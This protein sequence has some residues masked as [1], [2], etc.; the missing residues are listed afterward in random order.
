M[1]TF[2]SQRASRNI[3]REGIQHLTRW[4][5][6]TLGSK[7]TGYSVGVDNAADVNR[8]AEGEPP[9]ADTEKRLRN[10]YAVTWYLAISDGPGSAHE[11]LLAPNPEL[12]NRSPA[13]LLHEG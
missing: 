6:V 7:L 5:L 1:D 13:E 4:L 11:W 10:L 12:A 9:P 3:E 2:E 8:Y